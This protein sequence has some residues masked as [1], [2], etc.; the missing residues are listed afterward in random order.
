[1]LWLLELGADEEAGQG[2][3]GG[4]L[5]CKVLWTCEGKVTVEYCCSSEESFVAVASLLVELEHK[6][7]GEGS[8]IDLNMLETVLSVHGLQGLIL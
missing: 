5:A 8:I 1:M 3:V 2:Q 4:I 7:H 6:L